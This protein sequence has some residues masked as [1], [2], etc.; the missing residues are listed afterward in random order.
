LATFKDLRKGFELGP[1]EVLPDLGILRQGDI[2]EHIEPMVMD[3]LVLLAS[4]D[5]DVVTADQI[6]DVVWTGRPTAPEAIVQKIKVL[7]DRLGDDPKNPK[8]IQT[9]PKIGYRIVC[10][11]VV[12]QAEKESEP[13]AYFPAYLWPMVGGVLA[14]IV[15]AIVVLSNRSGKIQRLEAVRSVAVCP[16]ENTSGPAGEIFAFGVR[17]QLLITLSQEPMLRVVKPPCDIPV[18]EIPEEQGVDSVLTGSVQLAGDQV[19]MIARIQAND[20]VVLWS[21]KIDGAAGEVEQ[22]FVLHERV[23]E[24]V[25]DAFRRT[26]EVVVTASSRPDSL[27]TYDL[28]SLGEIAFSKRSQP[29]LHR[30]V[31][32]YNEAI[33]LDPKYGPA[34]LGIANSYLLLADYSEGDPDSMYEEAIGFANRGAELDPGIQDAV[35]TV[36]GFVHTKNFNWADA[37]K[38]FETA[39]NSSKINP[40]SFQTSSHHWYSRFLANVGLLEKSLE[41]AR[42]AHEMDTASPILNA[43]LGVAYHWLNDSANADKYYSRAADQEVGSWIHNLAYTL[44]LIREQRLDEAR[45]KAKEA[46]DSYGQATDW[47]DPVFDGL[48]DPSETSGLADTEASISAAATSGDLPPNIE[49]TLWALLGEGDKAMEAAW[50]LE[51]SGDYFEVEIFY[52][53]EFRVLREHEQFPELLEALDLTE[54]WDSIGC[55][56][57]GEQV[58]CNENAGT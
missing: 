42:L 17:E 11:V 20:G 10:P 39:I 22:V 38:A 9:H 31:E 16:F 7:R 35:G 21:Q 57:G 5:G 3:V 36:Y 40:T 14:I 12:P 2:E 1:W 58:V 55:H 51:A 45:Q 4:G 25:R 49:L 6:V 53:D 37:A 56:W 28:Y 8:Y 15:I 33:S 54:Y 34:Y 52:L 32:L 23:A 48:M 24:R 26:S 29:E 18:H 50:A 19:R 46:L 44:F 13:A 30:A 47:V 27:D 41:H 43:R